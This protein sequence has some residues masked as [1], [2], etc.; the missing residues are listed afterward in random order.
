MTTVEVLEDPEDELTFRSGSSND[1]IVDE[2]EKG[3]EAQGSVGFSWS[4]LWS[5]T[6]PGFLMSVAYLDP[7]N[8]KADIEAGQTPEGEQPYALLWVLFWATLMGLLLQSMA[9]KLGI[10]SGKH[11]AEH[12]REEFTTPVRLTLWFM[13]EVAIICVD[14]QEVLGTAVAI[15]I[16]S[17]EKVPLWVGV[18]LSTFS[19]LAFLFMDRY[20]M[21]KLEAV[22]A[23]LISIMSITFGAE[24]FIALPNQLDVMEGTFIPSLPKSQGLSRAVAMIGAVI[25]PHNLY[26]HSALVLSREVP[27][28]NTNKVKEAVFYNNIE[29]TMALMLSFAINLFVVCVCTFPEKLEMKEAAEALGVKYGI[30]AKYIFAVGLLASGC[31]ATAT[32]TYA[33]QYLM[34]GYLDLKVTA[35][36]RAMLSRLIAIGPGLVVGLAA[37]KQ[38]DAMQQ[39]LNIIQ[40]VQL[41]FA[42]LPLLYFTSLKSAVGNFVNSKLSSFV[43]WFISVVVIAANIYLIIDVLSN[44]GNRNITIPI[45]VIFL[46]IYLSTIGWFFLGTVKIISFR[47]SRTVEDIG[48]CEMQAQQM[49][50]TVI[51]E[52]DLNDVG[53]NEIGVVTEEGE[54]K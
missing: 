8:I 37:A 6:G 47:R 35:F 26:L 42:I 41:P 21:R 43:G 34:Q 46:M 49:D 39:W 2:E 13:A 15:Y 5:Y 22:F 53:T 3:V 1:E 18:I 27:V 51:S 25:M 20:G 38:A 19:A 23:V 14:C 12:C 30:S 4:L 11:L 40:S 17:G 44:S 45:L 10:S 32:S 54:I 28:K 24:Y 36:A 31:A 29:S 48:L 50:S 16:L 9:A 33:G 52:T 7:G